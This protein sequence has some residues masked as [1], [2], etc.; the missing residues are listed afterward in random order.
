MILVKVEGKTYEVIGTHC[1]GS[2]V[3]IK[4][5]NKKVSISIK[6]IEWYF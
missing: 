5:E 6:K 2:R 3:M 4:K 1:K